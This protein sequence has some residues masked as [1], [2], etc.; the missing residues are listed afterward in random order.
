MQFALVCGASGDIG[1]A[2]ANDLANQGWSLYLQYNQNTER[3]NEML[4]KLANN[5]PKQEFIPVKCDFT[6][7]KSVKNLVAQ[8]FSLDAI[9]FA[10]GTSKY[11]LFS[12]FNENEIESMWLEHVRTPIMLV[13]SLVSKFSSKTGRIVFV[14]SVYG[15]VGSAMEVPY[16]MLKGAQSA[17]VNAYAKEVASLNITV[18][19]VAPGAVNTKMN[20]DF[21]VEEQVNVENEIPMGR[22]AKPAEISSVVLNLLDARS[23]YITGQTIYVDG[24]WLK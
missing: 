20:K 9:I 12:E 7:Q 19:C 22:F 5:F 13:Q 17:F 2:I 14:G 10:Q 3:I 11:K 6:K 4:V 18:N 23:S 24:G 1:G 16:S 15:A 8:I 21:T